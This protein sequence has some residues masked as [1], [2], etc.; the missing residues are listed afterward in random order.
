VA[1]TGAIVNAAGSTKNVTATNLRLTADD[2]IGAADRHLTT[3]VATLTALSTG[4]TT[5]GIYLTQDSAVT[6]DTVTVSVTEFS[7]TASTGTVTDANQSDLVTGN[8]GNIVL[9]AGGSVTLNDGVYAVSPVEDNTDGK[10]ISAHGSGS[11]VIE[12]QGVGSNVTA[13]ADILSSRGGISLLAAMSVNVT[14]SVL[15]STSAPVIVRA[16][17]GDVIM[18]DA[19]IFAGLSPVT[20]SAGARMEP[21]FVSTTGK[22]DIQVS[23]TGEVVF[24]R[25]LD[26][27]DQNINVVANGVEISAKLLATGAQLIVNTLPPLTPTSTPAAIRIGGAQS[28]T[29]TELHLSLDEIGLIQDGFSLIQFGNSSQTNQSIVIDGSDAADQ[30]QL[31]FNDPLLLDISGDGGHLQLLGQIR[32]DSLVIRGSGK[33]TS[34]IDNDLSMQGYIWVGD[35][36]QVHS[37]SSITAGTA[38]T[39]GVGHL[40]ITGTISGLLS[41]EGRD[42]DLSLSAIGGSVRLDEAIKD[43][44]DLTITS[45]IDVS[46]GKSVA[47]HGSLVIYATG[48]VTF[49]NSLTLGSGGELVIKGAKS[50]TFANGVTVGGDVTIDAQALK[51]MGGAGSFNSTQVGSTLVITAAGSKAGSYDV[52]LGGDSYKEKTLTLTATDI[53]AIGRN[54]SHLAIGELGLGRIVVVCNTDFRS[55]GTGGDPSVAVA[56]ELRGESIVL[57]AGLT[58]S[59]IQVQVPGALTLNASGDVWLYSGID[60]ATTSPLSLSS[61]GNITMAQGTRLDSRGGDVSLVGAKVD[62]GTINAWSPDRKVGGVVKIDAGGGSITDANKDNAA[63]IFAKAINISGYGPASTSQGNVLE[64]VSELVQVSVPQG[65]V[66]RATGA[67][68]RTSFNAIN[69]DTLYR[70]IVVE[71]TNVVRV[72]K[73]PKVVLSLSDAQRIAEGIPSYSTLLDQPGPAPVLYTPLVPAPM[74][75]TLAAQPTLAAQFFNDSAVSRYLAPVS[76]AVALRGDMLLMGINLGVNDGTDDLLSDTSYGLSP[77]MEQSFILGTPGEQPLISGLNSFSQDDFEFWVDPLSV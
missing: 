19:K 51:F 69:A 52:Q 29:A 64:A 34:L 7:S 8:N 32:G 20:V 21:G 33:T 3:N 14:Q 72:T 58:A 31:V 53:A 57:N 67:N 36:L 22:V 54:F 38:G 5:A 23:A 56:I 59:A 1:D 44:D 4:T 10:A 27:Q 26:R 73:D 39:A 45:A 24:N 35:A 60:T 43:L 75:S 65:V 2:A 68:D 17:E 37:K 13:T 40:T 25:E 55:L 70:Q 50:V 41:G 71:G 18:P 62:V 30:S 48:D 77:Q 66:V 63:D 16:T 49:N 74:L 42:Q 6:V 46:F 47:I 11:V 12:A 28:A 76:A 61:G 15:I 9:V